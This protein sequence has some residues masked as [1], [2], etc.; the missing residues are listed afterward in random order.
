MNRTTGLLLLSLV[1]LFCS[2]S[3]SRAQLIVYK[4]A[5]D[6]AGETINYR[7]YQGG[8]YIAPVNGGT[9]SLILTQTTSGVKKYYTY[10]SF[11]ELFVAAKGDSRKS[12]ISCTAA[13]SVST[14]TFFAIGSA[15]DRLQLTTR[16]SD[17]DIFVARSLSGYAV[18]ADSERD[19]PYSSSS[20]SD[21]GVAGVSYLR[22]TMDEGLTVQAI[23]GNV[24]LTA[25]VTALQTQLTS[26]GYTNGLS[27]TTT[28]GTGTT[29]T[30]STGS[31]AGTTGT[32]G[33]GTTNTGTAS[34]S[35]TSGVSTSTGLR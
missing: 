21:I 27:T 15:D 24:T 32:S 8:Y 34:T 14:T 22:A 4:L 5:F 28:A 11:G 12:V 2:A 35:T 23:D 33:T 30:G 6:Q 13:N 19:L 16:S 25:E 3:A 1:L 9:G 29:G 31:T 10:A 18:S 20:A 26:Q 17:G 7:P